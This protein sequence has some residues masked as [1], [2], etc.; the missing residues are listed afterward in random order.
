[1]TTTHSPDDENLKSQVTKEL[2]ETRSLAKSFDF[3]TVKNGEWFTTLL[4]QVIKAYDRNARAAYFQKKYP[5]L[6]RAAEIF[7][8]EI[9]Q[10][11]VILRHNPVFSFQ[12]DA[13]G[14]EV[15]GLR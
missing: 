14:D 12:R 5:E 15:I 3:E 6:T 1:M 13:A 11:L 7:P 8:F 4:K 10:S 2:K 9:E